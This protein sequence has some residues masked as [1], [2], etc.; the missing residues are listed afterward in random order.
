M[1]LWTWKQRLT[2]LRQNEAIVLGSA[3]LLAGL[4]SG[5]GIWIFKQLITLFQKLAFD[6][7]ASELVP[8][9]RAGIIL[10]PALGGLL[11]G[12]ISWKWIGEERHHGVAGIIEA[13]ALAGGRLHYQRIPAKMVTSALSIGFGA[14]VGPEDP[15]VQIGA[16]SGSWIGQTFHLS[17][18]RVR[19][20]VAAGA[21]SGISAAFNAPIAGVF[22]AIEV[23]LGELGGSTPGI[24]LLAT[25]A[26]AALTQAL[27]SPEPAFHVP[28]Y[29]FH[30][31]WE[32]PIYLILGVLAGIVSALYV[33][34]IYLAQDQFRYLP[35][36]GWLKPAIAGIAVGITGIFL[37]QIFGVGYETIEAILNG[38]A[39]PLGL[40]VGLM[41]ARLIL[42]PISVGGG[43]MG[44]VFAPAL[45]IGVMLGASFGQGA[46][47]IFPG[48]NLAPA[49]FGLVGMAAV[50]A[51]A[52]HAP[53]TAILLLFEMTRD[54]R[55]ILPLMGAVATSL[56]ISRKIQPQSVYF[57]G[58]LRKGI[59][60][61]HGRDVDVLEELRVSE[62]M[63]KEY[64]VL[65]TDD[66]LAHALAL[67]QQTHRHGIPVLDANGD[68]AGILTLQDLNRH[69]EFPIEGKQIGE[70]C[71]RSLEVTYPD[72]SLSRALRKMSTFD[73]GRLPVVERENPRRLIGLLRRADVIRA[74]N[75]AL[76]RRELYRHRAGQARLNWMTPTAVQVY[77]FTLPPSSPWIGKSLQEIPLPD[78]CLIASLNRG[79]QTLVP[80]GNAT[81]QAGDV[82]VVTSQEASRETLERFFVTGEFIRDL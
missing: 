2:T 48:L 39:F 8:F 29:T 54:Y 17:E 30:S 71:T 12:I 41:L 25:I 6:M 11:V 76:S 63:E 34:L 32:L 5:L 45:F 26:S 1:N 82:L 70:I 35:V 53:L 38:E 56:L 78:H 7:L 52:I 10:I 22:F 14:S 20:L 3:A 55:I 66:S 21:A 81:L 50:L 77:E 57:F 37:P 15:S 40:L 58:L 19:V 61:Q 68:L 60:I 69:L 16:N 43:F 42:T 67:F 73:I 31:I 46:D 27:V 28:A 49:A 79:S 33:R 44:G 80:H 59:R 64:P 65:H 72:E 13:V 47:M 23:I 4:S 18:E 9:S 51:G 62:V 75:I 36:P 24:L 74:Y